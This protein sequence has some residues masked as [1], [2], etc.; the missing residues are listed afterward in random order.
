MTLENYTGLLPYIQMYRN[1]I[2]DFRSHFV[3]HMG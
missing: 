1:K 2:F 3:E